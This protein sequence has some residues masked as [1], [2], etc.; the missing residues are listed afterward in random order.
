MIKVS[1]TEALLC[2]MGMV[3]SSVSNLLAEYSEVIACREIDHDYPEFPDYETEE[4]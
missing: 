4:E 3:K 1:N 2:S